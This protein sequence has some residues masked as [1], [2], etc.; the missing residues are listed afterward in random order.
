M[1]QWLGLAGRTAVITG[2]GG[3]I[4]KAVAL[5]LSAN[6]V[7]CNVLDR[8]SELVDATVAR[9]QETVA[10]QLGTYVMSLTKLQS[11]QSQLQ[12]RPATSW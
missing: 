4:G 5:E 9:L 11:K 1:S 8:A 10:R 6:G 12:S 3:G 2:A 7:H